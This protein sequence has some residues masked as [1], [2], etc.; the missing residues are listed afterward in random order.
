MTDVPIGSTTEV[1]QSPNAS[2]AGGKFPKML[3]HFFAG[4]DFLWLNYDWFEEDFTFEIFMH[5]KNHKISKIFEKYE[6]NK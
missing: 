6:N 4:K 2:D 3:Q 1:P 5:Q